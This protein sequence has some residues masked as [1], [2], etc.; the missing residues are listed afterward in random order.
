MIEDL[1]VSTGSGEAECV[2]GGGGMRVAGR[3][4]RVKWCRAS[5]EIERDGGTLA[6]VTLFFPPLFFDVSVSRDT[7]R[8]DAKIHHPPWT[9]S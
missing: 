9:A 6:A 5:E 4:Q 7:P 1:V 8:R 2:Y 3:C